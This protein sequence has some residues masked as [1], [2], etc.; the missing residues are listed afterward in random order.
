MNEKNWQAWAF[1]LFWVALFFYIFVIMP[2][3]PTSS[4]VPSNCY[5]SGDC[6]LLYCHC[7]YI[8]V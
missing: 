5:V 8:Q 7:I 3:D 4:N 2:P 1:G 6:W